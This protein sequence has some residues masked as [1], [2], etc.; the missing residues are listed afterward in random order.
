MQNRLLLGDIDNFEAWF[1]QALGNKGR[2][3]KQEG[4]LTFSSFGW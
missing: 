4:Q 3:D 1:S 2:E